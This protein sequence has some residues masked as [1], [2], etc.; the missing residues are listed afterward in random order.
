MSLLSV[1]KV[2]VS[3]PEDTLGVGQERQQEKEQED[4]LSFG[5]GG[6]GEETGA[7]SGAGEGAIRVRCW[8]RSWG[9]DKEA[10]AQI[11]S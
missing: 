7:I 8:S 11:W 3:L 1:S 5:H 10:E 6:Q 4:R 2:N 9:Y